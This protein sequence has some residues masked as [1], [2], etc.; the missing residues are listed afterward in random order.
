MLNDYHETPMYCED[1]TSKMCNAFDAL[2]GFITRH[3]IDAGYHWWSI[4]AAVVNID[5]QNMPC[6][7]VD[8][9]MHIGKTTDLCN[10][11]AIIQLPC[12][13]DSIL[14][15]LCGM[16]Y[17]LDELMYTEGVAPMPPRYIS[18]NSITTWGHLKKM[19]ED[20]ND[21]PTTL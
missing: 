5:D 15:S 10:A 18:N 2:I 8:C 20:T 7:L 6:I 14:T 9:A 19:L 3:L 4:Q 12:T 21:T 1:A 13:Q 16:Y 11:R 17:R